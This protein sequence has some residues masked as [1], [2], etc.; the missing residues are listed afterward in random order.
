MKRSGS[1]SKN[2]AVDMERA[3]KF[4]DALTLKSAARKGATSAAHGWA[5]M[6]AISACENDG[7][8]PRK[9]SRVLTG[10]DTTM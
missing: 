4:T 3:P 5:A 2:M 6:S 10:L 9:V 1:D 8:V 7:V